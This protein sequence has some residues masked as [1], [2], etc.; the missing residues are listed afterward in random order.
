M[1]DKNN[2]WLLYKSDLLRNF[3]SNKSIFLEKTNRW[4]SLCY[5]IFN[6]YKQMFW[7]HNKRKIKIELLETLKDTALM[8]WYGDSC[9]YKNNQITMNTNL[10]GLNGTKLIIKYFNLIG[11]KS[12]IFY[13][14]K[15]IR[16]KFDEESSHKFIKLIAPICPH[17]LLVKMS[18]K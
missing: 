13:Q 11:Y 4:H 16:I 7:K 3:A 18:L 6:E 5:P 15:K 17:F 9:C 14:N 10:W 2:Q 12:N 1:R 8:I